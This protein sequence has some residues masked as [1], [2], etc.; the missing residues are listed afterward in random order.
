MKAYGKCRVRFA[1][2]VVTAGPLGARAGSGQGMAEIFG[3]LEGT[4]VGETTWR[5]V[6]EH[7]CQGAGWRIV[8]DHPTASFAE[9]GAVAEVE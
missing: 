3:C 8:A 4:E 2:S 9:Y 1:R 5:L 7:C 6:V